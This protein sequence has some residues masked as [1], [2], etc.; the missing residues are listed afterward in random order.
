VRVDRL[1]LRDPQQPGAQVVRPLQARIGPQ[2]G[3]PGLLEAVIGLHGAD[4]RHEEAIH[5][6]LVG[7]EQRLKGRELHAYQT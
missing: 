3:D 5:V 6:A 7:L 1:A 2:R 4:A